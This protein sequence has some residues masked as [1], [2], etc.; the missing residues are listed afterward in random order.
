L[1][2]KKLKPISVEDVKMMKLQEQA[3]RKHAGATTLQNGEIKPVHPGR[4]KD[5]RDLIEIGVANEVTYKTGISK[6]IIQYAKLYAAKE[7]SVKESPVA[8]YL[9]KNNKMPTKPE[10]NVLTSSI[11]KK[12]EMM[13]VITRV[14]NFEKDLKGLDDILAAY[15]H[16]QDNFAIKQTPKSSYRAVRQ[17]RTRKSPVI[18][19]EPSVSITNA[20]KKD[21]PARFRRSVK[22]KLR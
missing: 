15:K 20:A 2:I 5:V 13:H 3:A 8:E 21:I 6:D 19:T 14:E 11:L 1:G 4:I 9:I 12:S 22:P 16:V 17:L 7:G 10:F 18:K